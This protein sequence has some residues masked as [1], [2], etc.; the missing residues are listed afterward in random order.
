ML[1][2]TAKH[3]LEDIQE[4]FKSWIL[5]DTRLLMSVIGTGP[6]LQH[7]LWL[8]FFRKCNVI[9]L[10]PFIKP[11]FSEV[12]RPKENIDQIVQE[13]LLAPTTLETVSD[14]II[15]TIREYPYPGANA[16]VPREVIDE[17]FD[18]LSLN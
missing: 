8:N 9:P 13:T 6:E 11:K 3:L 2:N 5:E 4:K 7:A 17:Y 16:P 10:N 15:K 14:F 18:K 12:I 1:P